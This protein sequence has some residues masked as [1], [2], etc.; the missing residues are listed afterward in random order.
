MTTG[1]KYIAYCILW[2]MQP[3]GRRDR[4][5][6]YDILNLIITKNAN[7]PWRVWC[8]GGLGWGEYMGVKWVRFMT[9]PGNYYNDYY[10]SHVHTPHIQANKQTYTQTNFLL[11]CHR[12]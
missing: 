12:K 5:K 6:L 11:S 9:T 7:S 10:T 3:T 8:G 1:G 2:F 4:V